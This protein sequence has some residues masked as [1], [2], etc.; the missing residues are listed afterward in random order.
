MSASASQTEVSAF[1]AAD[2]INGLASDGNVVITLENDIDVQVDE[3]FGWG[4]DSE[5]D[6]WLWATVASGKKRLILNGHTLAVDDALVDTAQY[7]TEKQY[8][9][10]TGVVEEKFVFVANA[11]RQKAALICIPDDAELFVDGKAGGKVMMTAKVPDNELMMDSAIVMQRDVFLVKG[12]LTTEGGTYQAGRRKSHYVN[13][14]IKCDDRWYWELGLLGEPAGFWG[15]GEY[16]INGTAISTYG[17]ITYVWGGTFIGHGFEYGNPDWRNGVLEVTNAGRL[18]IYD[19]NVQGYSGA[20]CFKVTVN[21]IAYMYSGWTK[22]YAPDRYLWP[23]GA[24]RANADESY[25]S[26]INV[27]LGSAAFPIEMEGR[28]SE[29]A[30]G[31]ILYGPRSEHEGRRPALVYRRH[32]FD[33]LRDRLF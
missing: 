2:V 15:Y 27:G 11:F 30:N 14:A 21:S 10:E 16:A 4:Y 1:N 13:N 25:C 31:G 28:T 7:R 20:N 9:P 19:C 6:R 18:Y 33:N 29:S 17:G 12:R 8:N 23:R 3:Y 22:T 26:A 5:A 32:F 24:A